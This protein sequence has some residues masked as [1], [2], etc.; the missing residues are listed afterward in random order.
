MRWFWLVTEKGWSYRRPSCSGNRSTV[1]VP[2]LLLLRG[3]CCSDR[4]RPYW[5]PMIISAWFWQ[6]CC[7]TG[8]A[9]I[10]HEFVRSC[11]EV[12]IAGL[13]RDV[14]TSC[15]VRIAGAVAGRARNRWSI[16][17]DLTTTTTI[18]STR[19]GRVRVV[20]V[21]SLWLYNSTV[22]SG[23]LSI[24]W[25]EGSLLIG[26]TAA[27]CL[28]ANLLG[29]SQILLVLIVRIKHCLVTN[30]SLRLDLNLGLGLN[31]MLWP[32]QRYKAIGEGWSVLLNWFWKTHSTEWLV[33][34]WSS[35]DRITMGWW[36]KSV[37]RLAKV[38]LVNWPSDC[39]TIARTDGGIDGWELQS[40]QK[41]H[42]RQLQTK[43]IQRISFAILFNTLIKLKNMCWACILDTGRHT[44]GMEYS[45]PRKLS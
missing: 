44:L 26:C 13:S 23:R 8:R 14:G 17:R 16:G 24:S 3:G 35:E 21:G 28:I 31:L 2:R 25:I 6:Y 4:C 7:G 29:S 1:E 33:G 43:E 41:G 10:F 27:R 12:H 5:F 15:V 18:Y 19:V 20:D 39:S 42:Q 45:H 9:T 30:W 32:C 38:G 11:V 22:G 34:L 36:W 37:C 40:P